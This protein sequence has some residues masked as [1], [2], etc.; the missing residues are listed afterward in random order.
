MTS[1]ESKVYGRMTRRVLLILMLMIM[2][3]AGGCPYYARWRDSVLIVGKA[4]AQ[5][6]AARIM[7][8]C[9]KPK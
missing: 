8:Q 7:G 4:Q 5:A 3:M 2:A 1:D 9:E 6:E